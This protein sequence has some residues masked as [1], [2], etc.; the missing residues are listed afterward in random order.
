MPDE[1]SQKFK[2]NRG[3]LYGF[4]GSAELAS[5]VR[6]AIRHEQEALVNASVFLAGRPHA[7]PA[8][9]HSWGAFSRI[10]SSHP[11]LQRLSD[12]ITS[13]MEEFC[14]LSPS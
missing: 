12:E 8:E 9:F 1:S 5:T 3:H 6:Q 11:E 14:S 4:P 7:S 13:S 10:L 2:F